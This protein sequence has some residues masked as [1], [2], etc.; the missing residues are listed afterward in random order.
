MKTLHDEGHTKGVRSLSNFNGGSL[1]F[2]GLIRILGL[3]QIS[4]RSKGTILTSFHSMLLPEYREVDM[5]TMSGKSIATI[6]V[7]ASATIAQL[8]AYLRCDAFYDHLGHIPAHAPI[9]QIPMPIHIRCHFIEGAMWDLTQTLQF[10]EGPTFPGTDVRM[11]RGNSRSEL[12]S[13]TV[14]DRTIEI[15]VVKYVLN[16]T[17]NEKP[18][19]RVL[20]GLFTLQYVYMDLLRDYAQREGVL[21]RGLQHTMTICGGPVPDQWLNKSVVKLHGY[22]IAISIRVTG[23]QFYIVRRPPERPLPSAEPAELHPQRIQR[24]QVADVPLR[25]VDRNPDVPAERHRI[26]NDPGERRRIPNDPVR[27]QVPRQGHFDRPRSSSVQ[28][29]LS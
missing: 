4:A 15:K 27:G 21:M 25:R 28:R 6:K 1:L 5:N 26:P 11:T 24:R 14:D 3:I 8:M 18:A 12:F 17:L 13:A 16:F 2:D 19:E 7:D 23:P 10:T 9:R 29:R 20:Q 22:P